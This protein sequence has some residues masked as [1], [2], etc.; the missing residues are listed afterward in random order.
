MDRTRAELGNGGEML[1]HAVAFVDGETVAGMFRVELQHQ[2]VTRDFGEYAGGGDGITARITL[3]QG[4]L[5]QRHA[6]H[7]A[8]I[9]EHVF[10]LRQE[11]G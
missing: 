7:R 4:G 5:R 6:F 2:A 10:W 3:H 9:H 8:T 11:F 1:R